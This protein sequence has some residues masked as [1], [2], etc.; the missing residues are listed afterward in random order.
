MPNRAA[1]LQTN[2]GC[3]FPLLC[4]CTAVHEHAHISS[5]GMWVL[6]FVVKCFLCLGCL[7]VKRPLDLSGNAEEDLSTA[8]LPSPAYPPPPPLPPQ[9]NSVCSFCRLTAICS[10]AWERPL[11]TCLACCRWWRD[12]GTHPPMKTASRPRSCL[13]RNRP[14]SSLA[15]L[16]WH[17]NI[18]TGSYLTQ[19][20][21]I[22]VL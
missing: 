8:P 19:P 7:L 3:V 22:K 11:H 17:N 10:E 4:W 12:L 18:D 5:V 14:Q 20:Y 6:V 13:Q 16:S 21:V 15:R 9:C 2:S 1:K